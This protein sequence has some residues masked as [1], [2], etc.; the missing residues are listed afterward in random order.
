MENQ[1]RHYNKGKVG[2]SFVIEC[3]EGFNTWYK[4]RKSAKEVIQFKKR[5]AKD[6]I[7]LKKRKAEKVSLL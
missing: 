5:R 7:L 4:L 2:K 3:A 1:I 6:A